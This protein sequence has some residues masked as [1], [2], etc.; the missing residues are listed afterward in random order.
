VKVFLPVL[1]LVLLVTQA[2]SSVCGAQCV[3]HQLP[4][5]TAGSAH[6]MAHCHS[7]LH[8]DTAAIQTCPAGAHSLCAID[9]LVNKQE[10]A[11]GPLVIHAG[12]RPDI[13]LPGLNPASFPPVVPSPRSSPGSSPLITALRV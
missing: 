10:K 8:P 5:P 3:Q 4:N 13:L 9:L 12:G 6:V 2:A 1:L 11:A 7:M